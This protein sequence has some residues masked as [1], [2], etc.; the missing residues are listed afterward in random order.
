MLRCID[1]VELAFKSILQ[2]YITS[3][4]AISPAN[5]FAFLVGSPVI[6]DTNLVNYALK[7]RNFGGK[8]RFKISRNG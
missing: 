8:F 6:R 5:L 1:E 7:A 2:N 4:D 3:P